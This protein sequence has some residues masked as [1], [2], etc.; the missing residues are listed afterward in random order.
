MA[1]DFAT[2]ED[3]VFIDD[4]ERP[5]TRSSV[6]T[7]QKNNNSENALYIDQILFEIV[8]KQFHGHDLQI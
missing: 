7:I 1:N 5:V 3:E 2:P 4:G 8:Y 6:K